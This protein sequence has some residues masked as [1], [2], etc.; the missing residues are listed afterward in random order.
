MN[1]SD[2]APV[3]EYLPYTDMAGI[4]DHSRVPNEVHRVHGLNNE[5][6]NFQTAVE[7]GPNAINAN[8]RRRLVARDVEEDP[9]VFEEVVDTIGDNFG[10]LMNL[11]LIFRVVALLLIATLIVNLLSN[12]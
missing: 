1:Q 3:Y 4:R 8:K 5:P 9:T 2:Y 12:N 6:L 7:F 11:D 10:W